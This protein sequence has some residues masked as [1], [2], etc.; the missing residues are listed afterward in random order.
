[1]GKPHGKRKAEVT[2]SSSNKKKM[3]EFFSISPNDPRIAS[4]QPVINL[5]QHNDGVNNHLAAEYKRTFHIGAKRYIIFHGENGV[6]GE[7][8]SNEVEKIIKGDAE[9]DKKMHIGGS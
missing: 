1:M 8:M 7:V 3:G 5:E 2:I 9:V 6:V 4:Y